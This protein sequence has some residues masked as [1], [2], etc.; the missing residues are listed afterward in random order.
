MR[1]PEL[2]LSRSFIISVA[3]LAT[4]L[5]FAPAATLA[6]SHASPTPAA[7]PTPGP[8]DPAITTIARRE[9]VSWQAGVINKSRY[10]ARTVADMTDDKIATTSKALGVL[11]T[12]ESTVWI[13][14]LI[15]PDDKTVK[16][17]IYQMVCSNFKVY[18]FLTIGPDGKIQGIF[19]K[20][21][22]EKAN[23]S[24]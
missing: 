12:L 1:L 3:A 18:E 8:E 11:G 23:S 5:A 17:Y 14:P 19:F 10:D 7:T 24:Q 15:Y 6:R 22:L 16:G 2:M 13:G 4:I 20:D 9:F 21:T